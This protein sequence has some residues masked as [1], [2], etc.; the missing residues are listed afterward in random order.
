MYVLWK[1]CCS[2]YY[3]GIFFGADFKGFFKISGLCNRLKHK[4]VN[5]GLFV[6]LHGIF[7]FHLV[8]KCFEK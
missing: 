2:S 3:E 5:L 6:V 7:S 4:F 1:R 8:M